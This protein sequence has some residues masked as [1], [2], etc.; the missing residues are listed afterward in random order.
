[1]LLPRL[2]AARTQQACRLVDSV[3]ACRLVDSVGATFYTQMADRE[4]GTQD[5]AVA[6]IMLV[7]GSEGEDVERQRVIQ[8]VRSESGPKSFRV[9]TV[10]RNWR[11][12]RV[13]LAMQSDCVDQR[14]VPNRQHS[15]R[16]T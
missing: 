8:F 16:R 1:M 9:T 3:G 7:G 5:E 11:S 6:Y 10:G 2:D 13:A 4:R 12:F 15:N 14:L